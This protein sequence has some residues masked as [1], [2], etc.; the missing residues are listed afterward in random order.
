MNVRAESDWTVVNIM[1]MQGDE[2]RIAHWHP[3]SHISI[4]LPRSRK[5]Y[6][7]R[8]LSHHQCGIIGSMFLRLSRTGQLTEPQVKDDFQI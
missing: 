4:N 5:G 7:S 6:H 1:D 8:Q 3:N 2:F